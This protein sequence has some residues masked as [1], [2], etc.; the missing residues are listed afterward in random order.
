[1]Y[2]IETTS[3]LLLLVDLIAL[4]LCSNNRSHLNSVQALASQSQN[5][6]IIQHLSEL[7]IIHSKP[8]GLVLYTVV[9]CNIIW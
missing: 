5:H 8:N 6:M 7:S 2:L 4:D 1:M 3:P 9:K